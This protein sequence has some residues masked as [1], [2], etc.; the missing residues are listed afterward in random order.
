MEIIVTHKSTD[1]DALASLV[2][3]RMLY[4][5][6]VA[7]LPNVINPNLKDFL[8]IH[9]DCF[10]LASPGE[11]DMDQVTRMVVVDTGSWRRL[12]G[13]SGLKDR[14]DLHI[15]LWDH[16]PEGDIIAHEVH[17]EETGA[18]ITLLVR[19]LRKQKKL[20]TPIQATLFLMGIY[21]DTGSLTFSSTR[22]DDAHAAG[23]LLECRAD[24]K[25]LSTFLRHAYGRRQKQ[26][27][28]E[29]IRKAE[30]RIIKGFSVCIVSHEI[31]G[32]VP[33]LSMV[34]QMFRE[35]MNVDAAFGV[36]RDVDRDRCM[37]IGRSGVEELNIGTIMRSMGGGGHPGA[38]SALLKGANPETIREMLVEMISGNQHSSIMLSD[39]M[40]YPVT[41]VNENMPVET[42]ARILREE[43]CTGMPVVD[44]EDRLTGV[45]SRRDFKKIRKDSQLSAPVKAFMSRDVVSVT[46]E[47][48]AIDAVR[49]MIKHDIGRL[50]VIQDDRIIGIVTR[51][52]TM[53]Y[54]YDIL[55]D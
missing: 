25:I 41:T 46:P 13:V 12:E 26:V 16:H 9:K 20:L 37:A 1:F 18:N 2:A 31:Q 6:A 45:I 39:I 43:G 55:P 22:A 27:L 30:R 42:V 21:E 3:A 35:I 44:D 54:F 40:S 51:S 10:D 4:P 50:P 23:Y 7:V 15:T 28:F 17:R 48:S 14:Q 53:L 11:V 24:L 5:G 33:N 49:L 47:K 38:G 29:L 34:V 8:A 19:E 52:D 36:F 32:H